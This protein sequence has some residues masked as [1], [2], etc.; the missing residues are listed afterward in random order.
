VS[1]LGRYRSVRI[2]ASTQ[3][4]CWSSEGGGLRR[5]AAQSCCGLSNSIGGPLR[6]EGKRQVCRAWRACESCGLQYRKLP[7]IHLSIAL[8][9]LLAWSGVW[10]HVVRCSI[11]RASQHCNR[12]NAPITL[13]A[14]IAHASHSMLA[15]QRCSVS[16]REIR[17]KRSC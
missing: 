6:W 4:I 9:I 1:C 17:P 11:F 2:R 14:S 13:G 12:T 15:S 3:R 16:S 5:F 7:S 8:T 10:L